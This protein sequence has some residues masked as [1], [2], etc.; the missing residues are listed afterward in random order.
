MTQSQALLISKNR[1]GRRSSSWTTPLVFSDRTPH[2]QRTKSQHYKRKGQTKK[3]K[4][5]TKRRE[6]EGWIFM[7]EWHASETERNHR[8]GERER[9]GY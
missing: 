9:E 2:T 3:K 8:D 7:L 5:T 1:E 4:K 6:R